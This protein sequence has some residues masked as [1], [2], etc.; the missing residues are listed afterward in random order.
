M[1]IAYVEEVSY[2]YNEEICTELG[3]T[4]LPGYEKLVPAE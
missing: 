4:P 1:P 3:I 2:L